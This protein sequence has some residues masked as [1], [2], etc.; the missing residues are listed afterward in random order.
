MPFVF[1]KRG[2]YWRL[3]G[4][5]YVHDYMDGQAFEEAENE[6]EISIC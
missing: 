6:E 2:K 3:V 4:S 5:V 1:R